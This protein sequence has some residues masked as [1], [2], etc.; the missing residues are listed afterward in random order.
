MFDELNSVEN[1]VRDILCRLVPME[2][3]FAEPRSEYFVGRAQNWKG[4]G[5][6]YIPKPS[7][8]RQQKD[9][10]VESHLRDAL[11]K[12]NPEIAAKPDLADEVL[13]KL[14]AILLAVYTDGLVR[15]NE[16]FTSWLRGER[17]M[18]FGPNNQHTTVRL[19]DF[20]YWRNNRCVVTQQ[21]TYKVGEIA[22]R[23]DLVLLINGIP[24]IIGEAKAAA[25]PA[26][27]WFDGA[28]Q[29]HS[30]YEE[31]VPAMFVPNVFSFATE[32]KTFRYGS[33]RQPL[34]KWSPWREK[35][36]EPLSGLR[37][38]ETAV[39]GM[40]TPAII[41]DIL[42]NFTIFATDKRHR[43]IKVICRFQQYHTTNQ[44]VERVVQGRIKKGLIW[45]FQGSGKSLLMVFAAQ[46]MRLHPSLK[47][48]TVLIVV[49]RIDLDT[50]ITGTFTAADVP[51][52][53]SVEKRSELEKMLAQDVRKVL[54]TT[55]HKFG[56]SPGVLN[57]RDNI[58]VMVDEAHRT[59]EGDLGR[60]MREALPNAFLFGLTGTPINKRDRNTFFA[61]GAPEDEEGYM[62]RYS[63]EESIRDDATKPLHFEARLIE[64]RVDKEAIDEAY[65]NM[66]GHLSEDDQSNLA[67]MAAKMSVVVKAD[68]RV[69]AIV[70]DIVYHY[71][72]KIE[73]NGFKAMVVTF[74]REA[75]VLYKQ[76]MDRILDPEASEI[77]MTVNSGEREWQKYKRGKDEEEALL[78]RY[79]DPNDPLQILIVTSKLLTG[80]DA[81]ILQA[82]YLDKPM[83]EHNLLQ[84]ICRTNRP[85]PGKSHGLIVDYI[86]V[87][88]D[89]ARS[90]NFDEKRVQKVISNLT[91]LYDQ[92]PEAIAE[93]IAFFPDIEREIFGWEGLIAAQECLPDNDTRDAFAA[94]YSKLNQVWEALSPDPILSKYEKDYR[95]LSQVYESVK[96]PSGQGKLLWHTLGAKTLDL[97]HENIH[98]ETVHD[99]LDELVMDADFLEELIES[100]DPR[101]TKE[102]EIQIIGRLRRHPNH[103]K[104]IELGK[105]LEDIKNRLEQGLLL[106]ID[107]L[108]MLLEIAKNVVQVE[109]EFDPEEEQQSAITAL[110]DL[111][112]ETRTDATPKI[113]E[114]VVKDIDNIVR[115]VRFP[116][117]QQTHA[118]EREVKK[119]LRSTLLKYQLHKDQ[120]L[121][122]KAYGYI[123]EY[124]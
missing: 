107:Y 89:V 79:R 86:G 9:V 56:E 115:I 57:G 27:T 124:Y 121:F 93:C 80:F 118:G 58:I 24:L 60:K 90:L 44:I 109:K 11:I 88:D 53:V 30:V 92:L 91:E 36:M 50:Q 41:L 102:I 70:N 122:D 105:R 39:R 21:Y 25:R 12:L 67:K 17:S 98:V 101:K 78:D 5:W 68:E 13:Y 15:S 47:N 94:A 83:K 55:I 33:I 113:V 97:I 77:V 26:V 31:D 110:T 66:T 111:F 45:H 4:L 10:L 1:F 64:L 46:K 61:F 103:P 87:F 69:D 82:M 117:W 62:S 7:L 51:N 59:Q 76:A 16:E 106:S 73:P 20:D 43:K 95:W 85:Y 35:E 99:E 75:C 2:G 28:F 52:L 29:V 19:I 18:P 123:K 54:I 23:F 32:G 8:P 38:V 104:F 84:G 100:G 3:L 48:P 22:K 42:Q 114:Q 120:E 49:D 40:L 65:A 108:K 37:E 34:E 112:Y 14:R 96:P 71:Q 6:E 116:G 74:D 119:A 63:F 72:T 81:P